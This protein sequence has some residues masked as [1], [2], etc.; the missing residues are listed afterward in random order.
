MF[1][2]ACVHA[3]VI[4]PYVRSCISIRTHHYVA[5][6]P[7]LARGERRVEAEQLARHTAPVH[8]RRGRVYGLYY[9]HGAL[10]V[11]SAD[12]RASM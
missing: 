1:I 8:T 11:R 10:A 12:G 3:C 4:I 7:L 9:V 5:E 6:P 2:S